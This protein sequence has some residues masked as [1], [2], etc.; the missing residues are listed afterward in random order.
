MF[1]SVMKLDFFCCNFILED[2]NVFVSVFIDDLFFEELNFFD[3][4][5]SEELSKIIF[6]GL[7]DN[8]VVKWL[9]LKGN[10]ICVGVVE[11]LG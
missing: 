10:N 11:I 3:C 6:R 2:C 1:E 7:I 5:F 8:K 9:N 4:L